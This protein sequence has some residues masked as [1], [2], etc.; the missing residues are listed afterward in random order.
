MCFYLKWCVKK[1]KIQNINPRKLYVKRWI[2]AQQ[3]WLNQQKISKN[4][5]KWYDI[6]MISLLFCY[7]LFW[8]VKNWQLSSFKNIVTI[9][10]YL[11]IFTKEMLS[12]WYFHNKDCYWWKKSRFISKFKISSSVGGQNFL[13][14]KLVTYA[15]SLEQ[16]SDSTSTQHFWFK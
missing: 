10:K 15:V 16:L 4:T 12:P 13:Y 7:I 2:L 5:T 8:L 11:N 3:S 6:F 1:K 9:T 14:C